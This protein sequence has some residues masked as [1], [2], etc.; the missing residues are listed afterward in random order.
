MPG[1]ASHAT[2]D[3]TLCSSRFVAFRRYNLTAPLCY[4]RHRLQLQLHHHHQLTVVTT[5][6]NSNSTLLGLAYS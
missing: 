2:R 5:A 3:K 6:S 4:H 1:S